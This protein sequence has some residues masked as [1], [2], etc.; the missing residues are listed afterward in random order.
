MSGV[1]AG[2]WSGGLESEVRLS[3]P[4]FHLQVCPA[5]SEQTTPTKNPL[6]Q[7]NF[8]LSM[9]IN[10]RDLLG[11]NLE[12]RQSIFGLNETHLKNTSKNS[13]LCWKFLPWPA[14]FRTVFTTGG[15]KAFQMDSFRLIPGTRG[16]DPRFSLRPA[17]AMHIKSHCLA[18][19]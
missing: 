7:V 16:P 15:C 12:F 3:G 8:E 19:S 11:I 10:T 4:N 2:Y 6:V 9:Q 14:G 13:F 5:K 18:P 17:K 1:D